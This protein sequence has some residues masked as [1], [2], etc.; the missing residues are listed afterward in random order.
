MKRVT[1]ESS[2]LKSVGYDAEQQVMEAEFHN[3]SLY[4]YFGV[5]EFVGNAIFSAPS[6]GKYFSKSIRSS[7]RRSRY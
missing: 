2:L 6:A 7:L 5:S 1:V 4:R 3:G